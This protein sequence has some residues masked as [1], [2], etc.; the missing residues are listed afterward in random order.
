MPPDSTSQPLSLTVHS[1]PEVDANQLARTRSGRW[2]MFCVLLICAAPVVASYFTYY[3]IRPQGQ[4]RYGEL[5]EPQRPL[6]D[7]NAMQL[8]GTLIP[9]SKLQ[10]QWLLVSTSTAACSAQCESHLYLQRQLRETLGR[11]KDRVDWVWLVQDAAAPSAA[12][13]PALEGAQ[14]LHVPQEV[15]ANWLPV[16]SGHVIDDHIYVVDP[17]G[18]LMMRMPAGMDKEGAARAK[19]DI[20][21]LLRASASWDQAGRTSAASNP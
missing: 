2:K 3:V 5:I 17:Q 8:D 9:L 1:Q 14:V 11:D 16:Q 15:L 13:R 12:L 4:S 20:T 18:H 21:R 6:P 10:G 7:V 19:K